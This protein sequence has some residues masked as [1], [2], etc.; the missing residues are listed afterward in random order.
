MGTL[1][2][3]WFSTTTSS[4]GVYVAPLAGCVSRL[5]AARITPSL[6][7]SSTPDKSTGETRESKKTKSYTCTWKKKKMRQGES[8]ELH[9]LD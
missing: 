7:C 4:D 6:A 1:A 9:P 3:D 5:N 8:S 2:S